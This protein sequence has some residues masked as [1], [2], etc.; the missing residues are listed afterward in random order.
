MAQ[1]L[2]QRRRAQRREP[3]LVQPRELAGDLPDGTCL[4]LMLVP[5]DRTGGDRRMEREA[6]GAAAQRRELRRIG[7]A[8]GRGASGSPCR[9]VLP[10][11]SSTTSFAFAGAGRRPRPT[12]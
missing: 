2:T 1:Q 9:S 8:A 6:G 3:G 12:C 4:G 11:W 10:A 5:A 7:A